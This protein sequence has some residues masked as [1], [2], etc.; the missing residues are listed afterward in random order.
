MYY[1]KLAMRRQWIKRNDIK[2]FQFKRLKFIIENAYRYTRFYRKLFDAHGIKPS[3]F[4]RLSDIKKFPIITREQ[5]IENYSELITQDFRKNIFDVKLGHSG[6]TAG[7]SG[8][9]SFRILQNEAAYD[10]FEV[11]YLRAILNAGY[12][13]WYRTAY[14]WYEPFEKRFYNSFGLVKKECI[15]STLTFKEQIKAI[16]N[17]NPEVISYFS[18]ILYILAKLI[19]NNITINPKLVITRSEILSEKMRRTIENVFNAPVYD[20]YGS[21]EFSTMA[22]QCEER[23]GYHIDEDSILLEFIKENEDVASGELG[24]IIVT[25]LW[26]CTMPLIRY[27]IGDA[28]IP[29]DEKCSCGRKLSL[30]KSVEGRKNDLIE[31]VNKMFTPKA[32]IDIIDDANVYQFKLDQ[33]GNQNFNL[34]LSFKDNRIK[35]MTTA[36]ICR[37]LRKLFGSNIKINF[38]EKELPISKRGKFKM[39][40]SLVANRR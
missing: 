9:H 3:N 11:V 38:Q 4:K 14:Y 5:I 17:V 19:K 23:N 7:S 15:L 13:P 32:I 36:D 25:G 33:I 6:L 8:E 24:D 12:K 22:W 28:G 2:K 16:E 21:T 39:V 40:N 26:N 18:S 37:R 20:Q 30:L 29:L 1:L 31:I 35:D 10:Y 34:F 27:A